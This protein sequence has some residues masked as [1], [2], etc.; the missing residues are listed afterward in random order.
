MEK[1]ECES[2]FF[3]RL[4]LKSFEQRFPWLGGD[5]QTLRDTFVSEKLPI[6]NGEKIK[7]P[8]PAMPSGYFGKGYL[9]SI[10]DLPV[11]INSIKGL[12]LVLHGL[13][14][15]SRRQGLRRISCSLIE[16]G[17]A[18]LRLNLRG[19]DPGREL[20]GGTYSAKCNSDLIPAI[21]FAKKL[22]KSL[23]EKMKN[24]KN[25][26]LF[27][28]GLSLGGTILLNACLESSQPI[29]SKDLLL[30]GLVCISS[31]L[32]LDYCSESIERPRNRF[33]QNWLLRRLVRQTFADPFG[34]IDSEKELLLRF[35]SQNKQIFSS[36]REFDS[37][38]TAPRWGY[39]N[40][41][42]YYKRA[43]PITNFFLKIKNIPKSLFIQSLDDPWVPYQSLEEVK[44]NYH[45]SSYDNKLN[46]ILT[47]KGGHN[48]FHGLK[49]CWGDD[50]V[51]R[52]LLSII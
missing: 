22:C 23:E 19:A 36:I 17:F 26:P 30:D 24:K 13:G 29:H 38:I 37:A 40:V 1:D 4:K 51:V 25:I 5:L 34:L 48:G 3:N 18:V 28:V 8:I 44:L 52:W 7:I 10:L 43:S 16:A 6:E 42:D 12:V 41:C 21:V 39:K 27:G 45:N 9:L 20:A 50:L 49:G 14:G 46:F 33:Y 32:D 31:P 47:R 35:T 2:E 11:D 15:S